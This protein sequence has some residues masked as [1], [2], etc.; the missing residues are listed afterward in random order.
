MF[1][2]KGITVLELLV[3][4]SIMSGASLYSAEITKEVEETIATFQGR[5][6]DVQVLKARLPMMPQY[7]A[8]DVDALFA[9][10]ESERVGSLL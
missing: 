3:G 4:L 9:E 7:E 2:Q 5:V 1:K 6:L 8:T 10:V